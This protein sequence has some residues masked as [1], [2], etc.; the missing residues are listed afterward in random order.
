MGP[1]VMGLKQQ[2]NGKLWGVRSQRVN[3]EKFEKR[4]DPTIE[5]KI[6]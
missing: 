3:N 2:I 6:S 4:K 5:T 1:S